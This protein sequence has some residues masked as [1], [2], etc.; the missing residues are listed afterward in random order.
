MDFS[1]VASRKAKY[2]SDKDGNTEIAKEEIA[3]EKL[4]S[5]SKN[6]ATG[7]GEEME[8]TSSDETIIPEDIEE[9]MTSPATGDN[10]RV[11]LWMAL[12]F[13]SATGFASINIYRKKKF[14]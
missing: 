5:S 7:S 4:V 14:I 10:S 9:N 2:Y 12:L 13:V 3:V 6:P 8:D 11:W 1:S